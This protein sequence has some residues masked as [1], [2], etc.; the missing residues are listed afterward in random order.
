[1]AAV[2]IP[3]TL[4]RVYSIFVARGNLPS[5]P[6]KLKAPNIMVDTENAI[7][8]RYAEFLAQAN[9]RVNIGAS[10]AQSQKRLMNTPKIIRQ[11]FAIRLCIVSR[12]YKIPKHTQRVNIIFKPSNSIMP[13][14]VKAKQ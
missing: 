4:S 1:M 6:K 3:I 12:A 10:S 9:R 8:V 14:V 5:P 7:R 2:P 13:F 11:A